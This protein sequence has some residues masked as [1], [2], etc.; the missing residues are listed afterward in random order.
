M[1]IQRL[2]SFVTAIDLVQAAVESSAVESSAVESG[3]QCVVYYIHGNINLMYNML[4]SSTQ[5]IL[6]NIFICK[7][8]KQL[9]Y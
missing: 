8:I 3:P 2:K 1:F 5:S 4:L 9:M 7:C 6:S